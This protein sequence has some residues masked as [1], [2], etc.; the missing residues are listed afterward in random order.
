MFTLQSPR[1][2]PTLPIATDAN[3]AGVGSGP[4]WPKS[5][6]TAYSLTHHRVKP[7]GPNAVSP[8]NTDKLKPVARSRSLLGA[9]VNG[10]AAVIG[11]VSPPSP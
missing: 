11:E 4:K 6:K 7:V 3:V 5:C 8:A 1:H 2:I 10:G 9:T